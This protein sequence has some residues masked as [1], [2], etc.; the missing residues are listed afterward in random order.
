MSPAGIETNVSEHGFG[1]A[2]LAAGTLHPV[3]APLQLH[4]CTPSRGDPPACSL[5][6]GDLEFRCAQTLLLA[7]DFPPGIRALLDEACRSV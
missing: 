6:V 7:L 1:E 3:Q 4:P 2:W 5:R